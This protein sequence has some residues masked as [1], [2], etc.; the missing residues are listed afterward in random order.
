MS[1]IPPD[2]ELEVLELL[3]ELLDE[4][5]VDELELLEDELLDEELLLEEDELFEELLDELDELELLED[6]PPHSE[7]E[8]VF[9][10]CSLAQPTPGSYAPAKPHQP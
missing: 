4:L 10:A 9:H 3:E 8:T 7:A 5:L 2:V 6:E 1:F